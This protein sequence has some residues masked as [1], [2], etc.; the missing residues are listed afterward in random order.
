MLTVNR[1]LVPVDFSTCSKAGLEYAARLG[2]TFDAMLDVLHVFLSPSYSWPV[3]GEA[4]VPLPG[5]STTLADSG[6]PRAERELERLLFETGQRVS[7]G[8]K[9]RGVK[10]R[11]RVE[12]GDA[13]EIILQTAV[14]GEHDLIVMG[15]HGRRGL[16]H[17]LMGSVAEQVVRRATCP[18]LTIRAPDEWRPYAV[19]AGRGDKLTRR[20]EVA[21]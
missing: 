1:I 21:S 17:L 13:C 7:C 3:V 4:I 20:A 15:T 8:P 14:Q 5:E 10:A 12:V 11:S 18:V 2:Q 6:I 16:S 9:M 19:E